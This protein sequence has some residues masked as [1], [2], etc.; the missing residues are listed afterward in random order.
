MALTVLRDT[1]GTAA[2]SELFSPRR[3]ARATCSSR[4]L[5]WCSPLSAALSGPPRLPLASACADQ[6]RTETVD[7]GERTLEWSACC[8]G[9][10]DAG[11]RLTAVQ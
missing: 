3:A 10:A 11:Q 1:K 8:G 6:A 7:Q 9:T 5:S 2:I 4:R